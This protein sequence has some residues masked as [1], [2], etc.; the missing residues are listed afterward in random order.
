MDLGLIEY[1]LW[2]TVGLWAALFGGQPLVRAGG[3]VLILLAVLRAAT[4]REQSARKP[5]GGR[6][7]A[8]GGW[9][10]AQGGSGEAGTE[11]DRP[12]ACPGAPVNKT[13]KRIL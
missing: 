1:A 13:R 8:D 5:A 7:A 4:E 3:F 11:T 10:A 6:E 12:T 9:A 2:V